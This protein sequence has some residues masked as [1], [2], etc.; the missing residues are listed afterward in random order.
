MSDAELQSLA[1]EHNRLADLLE[2]E[3]SKPNMSIAEVRYYEN[4]MAAIELKF[5]Q[6]GEDIDQW[7]RK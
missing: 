1:E 3:Q 4:R 2:R 7:T 6:A 5:Q